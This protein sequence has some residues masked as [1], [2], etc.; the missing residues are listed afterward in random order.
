MKKLVPMIVYWNQAQVAD[1]YKASGHGVLVENEKCFNTE[2]D[3]WK[4]MIGRGPSK[5]LC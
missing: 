4:F 5:R 3:Y 1:Q 2:L